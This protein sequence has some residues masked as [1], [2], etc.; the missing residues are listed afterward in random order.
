MLHSN[1]CRLGIKGY[2][3]VNTC[4][5]V[6]KQGAAVPRIINV[7]NIMLDVHSLFT[8]PL[9]CILTAAPKNYVRNRQRVVS[10]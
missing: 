3:D 8:D 9:G 10:I 1:S 6:N 7:A 5:S 2:V 4:L